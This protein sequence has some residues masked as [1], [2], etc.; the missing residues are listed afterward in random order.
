MLEIKNKHHLETAEEIVAE[1]LDRLQKYAAEAEQVY[2]GN[3]SPA[4]K[5][6][7]LEHMQTSY[8]GLSNFFEK[9]LGY[10]V[11]LGDGFPFAQFYFNRIFYFRQTAEIEVEKVLKRES[12]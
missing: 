9:D 10:E 8:A 4:E 7:A 1:I 5:L 2:N 3:G 11:R 6:Q 12:Q